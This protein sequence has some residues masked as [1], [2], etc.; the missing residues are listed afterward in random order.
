M[1]AVGREIE[2]SKADL[3]E[4]LIGCFRESLSTKFMLEQQKISLSIQELGKA[5]EKRLTQSGS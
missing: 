2:A 1:E 5:F 4:E 3:T